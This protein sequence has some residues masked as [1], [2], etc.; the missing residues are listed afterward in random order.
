MAVTRRAWWPGADPC[1]PSFSAE[2]TGCGCSAGPR[3]CSPW[4]RGP[5]RSP[6]RRATPWPSAATPRPTLAPWTA[7][8]SR[9]SATTWQQARGVTA[10]QTSPSCWSRHGPAV[11]QAEVGEVRHQTTTTQ[12]QPGHGRRWARPAALMWTSPLLLIRRCLCLRWSCSWATAPASAVSSTRGRWRPESCP[13]RACGRR[14]WTTSRTCAS[15]A[16]SAPP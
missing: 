7:C 2:R 5:C 10:T 1:A 8:R 13:R 4:T 14:L 6:R 11:V 15:T 3:R 9:A 12:R 16:G